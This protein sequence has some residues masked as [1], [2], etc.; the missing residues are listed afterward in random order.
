MVLITGLLSAA[1]AQERRLLTGHVPAEAAHAAAIGRLPA[2]NTLNLAIGLP[3]RNQTA[4]SALQQQIY[5]P[6]SPNY[7]H[8]LTPEQFNEQFSPTEADYQA[9]IAFAKAHG[10]TVTGT[11]SHR[12]L[13]DVTGSVADIE[14]AF[15]T[16]LRTYRHPTEART[17]YAP[18][19]EPSVE[20]NVP[21]LDITGL[22]NF[23]VPR[24]KHRK[25]V[26]LRQS[27][28]PKPKAGSGSGGLYLGSDFRAAY[29]P[30][31][32]LNGTG[33]M[34]GLLEFDGYYPTDITEYESLANLPNVPLQKVLLDDLVIRPQPV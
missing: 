9:V 5:D 23:R 12:I 14:G 33:Q 6:A 4:F 10:L 25:G 7:R 27:A 21:V 16:T 13:L 20:T 26:P 18:D 31:V 3:L 2:T 32:A 17:F 29:A 1:T 30:G 15:Q 8:Y 28:N 11:H 19:V 22:S 34:I 24:P